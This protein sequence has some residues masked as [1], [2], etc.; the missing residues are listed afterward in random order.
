MAKTLELVHRSGT[1]IEVPVNDVEIFIGNETLED[2][3]ENPRAGELTGYKLDTEGL[4]IPLFWARI[5]NLDVLVVREEV[6]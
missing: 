1:R 5:E 3:K 6:N 4:G 2:G